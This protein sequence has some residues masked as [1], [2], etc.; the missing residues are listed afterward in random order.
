MQF[1][2]E[3]FDFQES[4]RK[5]RTFGVS[6]HIESLAVIYETSVQCIYLRTQYP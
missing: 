1:I 6:L 2:G 5:S 3:L 4:W